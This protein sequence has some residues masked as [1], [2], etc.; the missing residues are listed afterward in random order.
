MTFCLVDLLLGFR[1]VVGLIGCCE[2]II[3][4]VKLFKIWIFFRTISAFLKL[5]KQIL[6]ALSAPLN[7]SFSVKSWLEKVAHIR[8]GILFKFRISPRSLIYNDTYIFLTLF[9]FY[10]FQLLNPI[11]LDQCALIQSINLLV[12]PCEICAM[13][14]QPFFPFCLLSLY[15]TR[16]LTNFLTALTWITAVWW[17]F[18]IE[19]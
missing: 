10:P 4:R 5:W 2:A 17:N 3:W 14:V 19:F 1:K 11:K 7:F 13:L 15:I 8:Q 18:R 9:P 16:S 6:C 12:F